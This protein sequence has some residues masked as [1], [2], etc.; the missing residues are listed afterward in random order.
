MKGIIFNV[1]EQTIC[2]EHGMQTWDMLLTS[3]G[4]PGGYS[5]LGDYPD[6]DFY[7]LIA[8][9]SQ[10]LG[11]PPEELTRHLGQSALVGLAERYP[12]FFAPHTTTRGLLLTL[13]DVVHAEVRKL[14]PHA[15]PPEFSFTDT[16]EG[17]LLVEYRSAR[18]LCAFADG[19][20][21]GAATHFGE[22]VVVRHQLCTSSGDELCVLLCSFSGAHEDVGTDVSH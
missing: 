12:H 20:I 17:D 21:V 1:V 22:S 19:M 15:N 13:N 18:R 5:S 3:S 7:R 6:E 9:G 11:S 8:V 4:L 16:P 10:A 14:Y 2:A